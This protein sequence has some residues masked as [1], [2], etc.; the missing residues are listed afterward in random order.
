MINNFR[1][2]AQNNAKMLKQSRGIDYEKAKV[3]VLADGYCKAIDE[4]NDHDKDLFISALMLRFWYVIGKL[5][6][7]SPIQGFDRSEFMAWLYEAI[8][9]AC[10]Y[11]KWQDPKNKVNAQ[12]C[13]NQCVNTIRLQHYY[14]MNLGKDKANYNTVS[15][16]QTIDM[17]DEGNTILLDTFEDEDETS[18]LEYE[19]S[20]IGARGM[21]QK[22]IDKEKLVEAIILDTIA[23]GDSQKETKHVNKYVDDE[24]NETKTTNYSY[25]F[26]RFRCAKSLNE[27]PED[28]LKYF[29]SN[30]DVKKELIEAAINQIKKA[31]NAKLYSYIDKCLAYC[32]ATMQ[33]G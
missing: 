22:I 18:K 28:Y 14:Q 27:L 5:E 11:R 23:F 12:Q 4:N 10:K 31:S 24:G 20:A 19:K 3:D 13:I 17:K 30:Y 32:K 2:Q 29:L 9:Y 21:I 1:Q 33:R 6:E 16:D 15:L 26:W 8:E 25:E 7:K